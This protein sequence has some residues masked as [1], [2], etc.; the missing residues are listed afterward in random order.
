L[1][2][3]RINGDPQ[4]THGFSSTYDVFLANLGGKLQ[5]QVQIEIQVTGSLHYLQMLQTP[6]GFTCT[7]NGPITCTGP[8]GGFGDTSNST[9]ADFEFQVQ[10]AQA[11]LG[12]ISA[13]ADPEGQIQESNETNNGQTL[14]VT[15]K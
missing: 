1:T 11:G 13:S 5:S 6:D 15:V 2:I 10:P 8:L 4:L 3:T 7:G 12:S 9:S 14:A